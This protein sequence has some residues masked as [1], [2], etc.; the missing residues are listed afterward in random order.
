MNQNTLTLFTASSEEANWATP[1]AGIDEAGRGCLAGPV[2]AGAC[3]L[4]PSNPIEGL[5]DS[6]KLT[7]K[8]RQAL[9]PQ[10]KEKALAWGI[11]VAWPQ[12][13]DRINILQSTFHAMHRAVQCLKVTP[14]LL[15][16]DGNAT[17]P[18]EIVGNID[19]QCIVKGDLKIQAISAA[20]ILAKTFRDDLMV[21]LDKRYSGYGF[22]GHKGYGTKAHIE[23]IAANGPCRMHRLTF[24]KVKPEPPKQEQNSLW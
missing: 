22:A 21:K 1:F 16:I 13:I 6:K 2:V 19:Q 24:A 5:T 15:A 7:E 14:V 17:I 12:E 3:I 18:K 8:R 23:A 20:S 10:I 4:D 11:G 9:Y